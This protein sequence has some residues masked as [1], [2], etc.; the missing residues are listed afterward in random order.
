MCVGGGG[1]RVTSKKKLGKQRTKINGK[2]KY[3]RHKQ[4]KNS[5]KVE[6]K[7]GKKS[8]RERGRE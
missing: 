2:P 6:Q 7:G 5:T 4:I 1:G 3:K 8:E